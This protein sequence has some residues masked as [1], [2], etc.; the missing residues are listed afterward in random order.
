M[1][2]LTDCSLSWRKSRIH[3]HRDL[4]APMWISLSNSF[5]GI[6]AELK[7]SNSKHLAYRS[8]DAADYDAVVFSVHVN[9]GFPQ[10]HPTLALEIEGRN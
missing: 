6:V 8:Q 5:R 2:I 7:S 1:P 3:M 10:C 4:S 9:F